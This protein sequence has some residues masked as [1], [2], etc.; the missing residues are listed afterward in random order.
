MS[1]EK[2]ATEQHQFRKLSVGDVFLTE[3][4]FVRGI[5]NKMTKVKEIRKS[6]CS[7]TNCKDSK[8]RLHGMKPVE[9]VRKLL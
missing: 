6:C 2:P 5:D 3:G 1:D 9:T 4:D 8:G 7:F